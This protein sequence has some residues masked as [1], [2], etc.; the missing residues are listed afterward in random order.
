MVRTNNNDNTLARQTPSIFRTWTEAEGC[1]ISEGCIV[2][3]RVQGVCYRMYACEEARRL[4]LTG[5]VKN[6]RGGTVELTAEGPADSL[7][8]LVARC[9]TGPSHARVT[10]LTE[11]Y[12]HATGEFDSF[13]IAY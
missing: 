12:S 5:W 7:A 3:G 2:E 1:L 13:T 11:E 10:D 9:R 4:G 6:L 8:D